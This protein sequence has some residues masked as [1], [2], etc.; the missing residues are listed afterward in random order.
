MISAENRRFHAAGH[1]AAAHYLAAGGHNESARQIL[2]IIRL[3]VDLPNVNAPPAVIDLLNGAISYPS[4]QTQEIALLEAWFVDP[5]NTII[6][7]SS[8]GKMQ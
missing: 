7:H 6:E 2:E 1:I 8:A 5:F 3:F 4:Q